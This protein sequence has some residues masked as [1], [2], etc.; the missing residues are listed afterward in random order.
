[1]VWNLLSNAVKFTAR[2]VASRRAR[3]RSIELEH[4]GDR[5]RAGIEREFLPHVFERFQQADSSDD[6]PGW[7]PRARARDRA[8][9]RRAARWSACMPRASARAGRHLHEAALP[10]RGDRARASRASGAEPQALEITA[11]SPVTSLDGVRV[12]VVDDEPDARDLLMAVLTQAGANASAASSATEGFALVQKAR[13]H[14]LVSDLGMQDIDGYTMMKRI[15]LLTPELGGTV[16]AIALSAYTR[17]EDR[18]KALAVGFNRH[19]A[20]PV[21]PDALVASVAADKADKEGDE[22]RQCAHGKLTF[23][24]NSQP[25]QGHQA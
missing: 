13:A 1:M 12:L 21:N 2:R 23:S 11:Q 6:A 15:R 20:K 18:A 4:H 24:R 16:P 9:H 25:F 14:V 22:D 19:I 7:R 3:V 8:A 10:I 17:L 5:H